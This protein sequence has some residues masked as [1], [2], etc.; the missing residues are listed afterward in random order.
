MHIST[1]QWASTEQGHWK[2]SFQHQPRQWESSGSCSKCR[3]YPVGHQCKNLRGLHPPKQTWMAAAQCPQHVPLAAS[4]ESALAILVR[5][6]WEK[7]WCGC[8]SWDKIEFVVSKG[9]SCS[10]SCWKSFVTGSSLRRMSMKIH[11]WQVFPTIYRKR[12]IQDKGS[13]RSSM[14]GRILSLHLKGTSKFRISLESQ[15][16]VLLHPSVRAL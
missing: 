10:N 4:R 7:R 15:G 1:A 8:A 12:V 5:C 6:S 2:E 14:K 13:D 9:K 11:F 3:S 16:I